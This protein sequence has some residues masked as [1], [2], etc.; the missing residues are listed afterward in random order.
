MFPLYYRKTITAATALLFFA[1]ALATFGHPASSHADGTTSIS[2]WRSNVTA[3]QDVERQPDITIGAVSDGNINI[4]VDDSL[5]SQRYLGV[6]ASFTDSSASLLIHLKTDQPN[7]YWALMNRVFSTTTGDGISLS[8][9][10]L[11]EPQTLPALH[12]IGPMQT[13]KGQI[14]ILWKTLA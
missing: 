7:R 1:T 6:G 12:H 8:G 4:R 9:E 3:T 11:W 5:Q 14:T 10:Y 2:A 13:V